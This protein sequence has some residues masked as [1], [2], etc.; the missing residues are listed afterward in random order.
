MKYRL[1]PSVLNQGSASMPAVAATGAGA[2]ADQAPA[3]QR[4]HISCH[5]EKWLSLRTN[6]RSCVRGS[7]AGC[8]SHAWLE[9][10]GTSQRTTS[11]PEAGKVPV[12][13]SKADA[14]T[15]RMSIN[16]CYGPVLPV[17]ARRNAGSA[18]QI[19]GPAISPVRRPVILQELPPHVPAPVE[20]GDYR[21]NE[22]RTSTSL[23]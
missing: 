8:D 6:Q 2:G 5:P 7:M 11:S 22:G 4:L 23:K 19:G 18:R 13:A 21:V 9:T 20:A 1:A 10:P 12:A 14:R 3:R 15:V 16:A 17:S